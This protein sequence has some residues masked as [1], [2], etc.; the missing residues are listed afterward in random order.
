MVVGFKPD[1]GTADSREFKAGQL[2]DF[3][4]DYGLF[5]RSR[6]SGP[7]ADLFLQ[8]A[9]LRMPWSNDFVVPDHCPKTFPIVTVSSGLVLVSNEFWI[10]APLEPTKVVDI[11]KKLVAGDLDK[12]RDKPFVGSVTLAILA[13][14]E[15][16]RY[17]LTDIAAGGLLPPQVLTEDDVLS[18]VGEGAPT[19]IRLSFRQ[20]DDVDKPYDLQRTFASVPLT[21]LLEEEAAEAAYRARFKLKVKNDGRLF[22]DAERFFLQALREGVPTKPFQVKVGGR[23]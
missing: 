8:A 16:L 15:S 2:P 19:A 3:A 13:G 4:M 18:Q 9:W 1:G 6:A 20:Q 12:G 23:T 7:G 17:N 21:M 22:D 14:A 11:I 5:W 10:E